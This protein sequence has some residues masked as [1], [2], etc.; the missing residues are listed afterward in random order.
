MHRVIISLAANHDPLHNL[1]EARRCL[2]QILFQ[3]RF[4]PEIWTDP[5]GSKRTDKY[6]NQLVVGMTRLSADELCAWLKETESLLGRTAS[7]R[8]SGIVRIDLDLLL[9]DDDRYHLKDWD[10]PYVKL[11]MPSVS[12]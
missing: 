12:S 8:Q 9:Y 2:G 5:I 10:R 11:L 1:S 6:L 3:T 7:D 4:S